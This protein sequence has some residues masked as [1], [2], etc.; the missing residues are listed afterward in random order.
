MFA[1]VERKVL[2][3][4]LVITDTGFDVAEIDEILIDSYGEQKEPP[5]KADEIDDLSNIEKR[6]KPGDIWRLGDHLLLCGDALRKESYE[7]LFK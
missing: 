6:V 5:D 7:E 2:F 3:E 1:N 4:D